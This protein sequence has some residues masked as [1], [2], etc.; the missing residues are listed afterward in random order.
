MVD[1]TKRYHENAPLS[2]SPPQETLDELVSR[3][4]RMVA[5]THSEA[6]WNC[7][8]HAPFLRMALALSGKA[9]IVDL[10]NITTASLIDDDYCPR[11]FADQPFQQ[12]K[13]DFAY[14]LQCPKLSEALARRDALPVNATNYDPVLVDPLA[15]LIE[16][17]LEKMDD[18]KR[19]LGVWAFAQFQRW[20]AVFGER[21]SFLPLLVF[22]KGKAYVCFAEHHV[23]DDHCGQSETIIYGERHVGDVVTNEGALRVLATLA[24]LARWASDQLWPWMERKIS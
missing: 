6:A 23:V 16:T 11:T 2:K 7:D 4:A 24:E 15:V 17:K 22:L 9:H 13:I 21:P 12:H 14:T 20:L 8:V 19:Q 1:I 3:A 18:A 10:C 5:R